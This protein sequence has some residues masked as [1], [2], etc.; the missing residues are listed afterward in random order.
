MKIRIYRSQTEKSGLLG[1]KK[2]IYSLRVV[3]EMT[4]EE[5]RLLDKYD[6]LG[7]QYRIAD[8]A[9]LASLEKELTGPRQVSLGQLQKGVDWTCTFLAEA[10]ARI[11][12]GMQSLAERSLG[13]AVAREMWGG[14]EVIEVEY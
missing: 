14:E 13:E 10:F 2:Y 1:G 8:S 11:P 5:T 3:A 7:R 9:V 4:A 12:A 6:Y